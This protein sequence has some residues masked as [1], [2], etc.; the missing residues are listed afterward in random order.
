MS[1]SFKF[2]VLF[3]IAESAKDSAKKALWQVLDATS[4]KS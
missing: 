2:D 4:G 1:V 3:L